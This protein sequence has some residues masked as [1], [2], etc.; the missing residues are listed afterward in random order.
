MAVLNH[1]VI[2]AHSEEEECGSSFSPVGVVAGG[3]SKTSAFGC[4]SAILKIII[5]F[6]VNKEKKGR[7][8]NIK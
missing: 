6:L 8:Q 2:A 4:S 3:V 1:E 7:K 5:I